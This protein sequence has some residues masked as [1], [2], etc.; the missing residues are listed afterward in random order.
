M[1]SHTHVETR[2]LGS[3][4]F[5]APAIGLG[6][7]G[8]SQ[9]YGPADDAGAAIEL[10]ASDLERLERVAS[11]AAWAGYRQSFAARNTTRTGGR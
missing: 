7:M 1:D 10:S 9:G 2:A 5:T 6:C 3:A 11:R 8:F 4:G